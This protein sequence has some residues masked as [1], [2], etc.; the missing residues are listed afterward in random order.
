MQ[1]ST[2][3]KANFYIPGSDAFKQHLAPYKLVWSDPT[4][5]LHLQ[6]RGVPVE[7]ILSGHRQAFSQ[8]RPKSALQ[9]QLYNTVPI[10]ELTLTELQIALKR[11]TASESMVKAYDSWQV[12]HTLQIGSDQ[13]H[14]QA[15]P[16]LFVAE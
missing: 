10:E 5:I 9:N 12:C 14:L 1:V 13:S 4:N 8:L 6:V 7:V 2:S 11:S 15:L 16:S 3:V